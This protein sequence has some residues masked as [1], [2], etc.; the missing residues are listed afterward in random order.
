MNIMY[1]K[2]EVKHMS[3]IYA[4]IKKNKSGEGEHAELRVNLGYAERIISFDKT[5]I[6]EIIGIPIKDIVTAKLGTVWEIK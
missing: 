3:K 2:K 6:A 5:L 1:K 4:T